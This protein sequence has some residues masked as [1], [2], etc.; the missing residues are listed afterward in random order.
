[1]KEIRFLSLLLV[2][3]LFVQNAS[4]ALLLPYS[5]HYQG[6]SYFNNNGMKGFVEFA[7]YNTEGGNEWDGSGFASPGS[8]QYIYAY[9]IFCDTDSSA[10]GSFT[11]MGS[12]PCNPHTLTGINTM[13]SQNPWVDSQLLSEEGIEP[14]DMSA[15]PTQTQA[16]WEFWGD[17]GAI[18]IH[19][20]YSWFLIFS[21]DHDWTVGRYDVTTSMDDGTGPIPNPEPCTVALLG[22]GSAILYTKR[23]NFTKSYKV[24]SH[25]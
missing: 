19:D 14:T 10:I 12:D 24:R 23:R 25:Y 7:V 17:T 8:G 20:E 15:N 18:L 21:S 1:M 5:S 9:Q 6:R 3:A 22:I 4:A 13:S 11:I 2:A 16:T